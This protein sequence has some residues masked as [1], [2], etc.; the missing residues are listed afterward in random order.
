MLKETVFCTC[1]TD[2]GRSHTTRQRKS[3]GKMMGFSSYKRRGT[4]ER[5]IRKIGTKDGVTKDILKCGG[6]GG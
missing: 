3:E 4:E 6:V 5:M 1:N 2:T